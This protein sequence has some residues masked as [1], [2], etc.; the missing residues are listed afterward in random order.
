MNKGVTIMLALLLCLAALSPAAQAED[1]TG[2]WYLTRWTIDYNNGLPAIYVERRS[3]AADQSGR[4]YMALHDPDTREKL[5]SSDEGFRWSVEAGRFHHMAGRNEDEWWDAAYELSGD[6][7][8]IGG[9]V[10][11]RALIWPDAEQAPTSKPPV[12]TEPPS[13]PRSEAD[14]VAEGLYRYE[15]D[16]DGGIRILGYR[17][18][19]EHSGGSSIYSTLIIPEQIDGKPVRSIGNGAFGTAWDLEYV[20]LPEGLESIGHYVFHLCHDIKGIWLPGSLKSIGSKFLLAD[21]VDPLLLAPEG[22][23]AHSLGKINWWPVTAGTVKDLNAPE[24]KLLVAPE[25]NDRLL[26]AG[27]NF[28]LRYI[29]DVDGW[30]AFLYGIKNWKATIA[31]AFT[32]DLTREP[33][34]DAYLRQSSRTKPLLKTVVDRLIGRRIER[35]SDTMTSIKQLKTMEKLG[36]ILLDIDVPMDGINAIL[37]FVKQM[38]MGADYQGDFINHYITL[39]ALRDTL[40]PDTLLHRHADEL[41]QDYATLSARELSKKWA[42]GSLVF[43]TGMA[44]ADT[45]LQGLLAGYDT[46]DGLDKVIGL[47]VIKQNAYYALEKTSNALRQDFD[48]DRLADYH[49]LFALSRELTLMEYEAMRT[50]YPSNSPKAKYLEQEIQSL[51]QITPEQRITAQPYTGP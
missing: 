5:A 48:Q 47:S 22:S 18:I 14:I 44:S 33:I 13:K 11:H 19:R 32:A 4:D 28:S 1:L 30:P 3:L 29:E 15:E 40:P 41:L 21:A 31:A 25:A 49:L 16:E 43:L 17:G 7:L 27:Y 34:S 42:S 8:R 12:V 2:D 6:T 10:Y 35:F 24:M 20:I 23:Y 9:D 46:L 45:I 38:N 36:K 39:E 50:H 26:F 37:H 51:K